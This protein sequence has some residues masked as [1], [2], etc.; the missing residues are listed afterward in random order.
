M[1]AGRGGGVHTWVDV[2]RANRHWEALQRGEAHCCVDT[3]AL[4]NAGHAGPGAEVA[5]DD[6]DVL[7]R[8]SQKLSSAA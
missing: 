7:E 1:S 3:D 6:V 8:L 5:G 4:L 2:T